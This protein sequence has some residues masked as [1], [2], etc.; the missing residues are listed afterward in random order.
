MEQLTTHTDIYI[1]WRI[2]QHGTASV[3]LAPI[4][5]TPIN[6]NSL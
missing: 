2:V 4:K 5:A 3:G 6:F 1:Y